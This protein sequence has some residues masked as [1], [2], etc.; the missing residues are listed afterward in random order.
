MDQDVDHATGTRALV[1]IDKDAL[2]PTPWT[3]NFRHLVGPYV[4]G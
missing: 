1:R 2:T 4:R 3:E